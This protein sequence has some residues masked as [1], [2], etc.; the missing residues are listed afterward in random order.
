MFQYHFGARDQTA[1]SLPALARAV[2]PRGAYDFEIKTFS[3][4]DLSPSAIQARWLQLT[5][6]I[7]KTWSENQCMMTVPRD[8][9][10]Y[11]PSTAEMIDS[12]LDK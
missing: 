2:R 6:L 7:G 8:P 10:P 5:D 11:V 3:R 12:A 1:F 9:D 4:D